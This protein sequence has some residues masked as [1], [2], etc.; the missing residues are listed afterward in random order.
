M[1]DTPP[2]T[3]TTHNPYQK[4]GFGPVAEN[5]VKNRKLFALPT[6]VMQLCNKRRFCVITKTTKQTKDQTAFVFP[7]HRKAI[8]VF[9]VFWVLNWKCWFPFC[10]YW[11]GLYMCA[12]H[13]HC[14]TALEISCTPHGSDRVGD[15]GTMPPPLSPLMGAPLP[16]K[17]PTKHGKCI[18][19]KC[20]PGFSSLNMLKGQGH[21]HFEKGTS[22]GKS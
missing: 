4:A 14:R 20:R 2:V 17:V 5:S 18:P 3:D 8:I 1:H 9:H 13:F 11:S 6:D 7:C 16:P 10:K 19:R 22:I 21:F 15:G 12:S